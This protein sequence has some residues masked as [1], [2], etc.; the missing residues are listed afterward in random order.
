MIGVV[1]NML[2]FSTVHFAGLPFPS[3]K[4]QTR[5]VKTGLKGIMESEHIDD[6]GDKIPGSYNQALIKA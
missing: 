1:I 3:R 2:R 4:R 6:I 5:K